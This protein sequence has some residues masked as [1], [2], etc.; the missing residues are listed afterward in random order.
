MSRREHELTFNGV[1]GSTGRPLLPSLSPEEI[2]ALARGE[3]WDLEHLADLK[4][5]KERMDEDDMGLVFGESAKRLQE[6]GWGVIFSHDVSDDVK[7]AL[8][9]LLRHRQAEAAQHHEDLYKE[10]IYLPGE[11]KP[12]F[13]ARNKVGPG[14]VNPH[15]LPYYLLIVGGP[16]EIP[17]SFQYQLDVP[18]A[19]GRIH[20][21]AVED[22][23]RYARTVVSAETAPTRRPRRMAFFGVANRDDQ[24]TRR[25]LRNLVNP[26]AEGLRDALRSG[27]GEAPPGGP[28]WELETISGAEAVKAS[29]ARILGGE[30]T[31][32]LL[33][34]ASHGMGFELDDPRFPRH[35]GALLCQDW[36]G[37]RQWREP[38]PVD[39]YFSCDDLGSQA[40][41]AGLMT[42]HFACYGAGTPKFDEYAHR[43]SA[44]RQLARESFVAHLPQRLLAHPG[45]GA[46]A[47]VG[48]ID[49]AWSYSFDWKDVPQNLNV[50]TS[51]FQSLLD[52]YP[53]G[54]AMEYFNLRYAELAADLSSEIENVN[55]GLTT[56]FL[57]LSGMWTAN[58]DARSYVVLG[59][60][61]VRLSAV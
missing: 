38:I 36:P 15:Q 13:L 10:L 34:T 52:G 59:D 27:A 46:L 5:H 2:L 37:P 18:Y 17:F 54:A 55:Y 57:S 20:F 23:A 8:E 58:N 4:E 14:P 21:E 48:H 1:N 12:K 61:A 9:P 50:F 39:H 40:D 60:P 43:E 25:S 35:Q 47:V 26:L 30:A 32:A 45:G 44:R 29:L 6:S 31:P 3:R 33:F 49:R 53:I 56:D 42:F 24:P 16:D 41:L 28:G 22:F 11:S 51:A 19:V 7:L